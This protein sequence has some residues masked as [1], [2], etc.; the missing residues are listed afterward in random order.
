MHH[1][2]FQ[3]QSYAAFAGG[4]NP[5][6]SPWT[7]LQ[8]T[9]NPYTFNPAGINPMTLNPGLN[10]LALSAGIPF[11]QPNPFGMQ[12]GYGI[13]QYQQLQQAA[14]ILAQNPLA[15]AIL[16]NPVLAQQLALQAIQ[17]QY[18][19]PQTG[20]LQYGQ[21]WPAH[22][23]IGQSGS[24]VFGQGGMQSGFGQPA[25]GQQGYQLAPQ[26]WVGQPGVS[27]FGGRGIY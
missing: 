21:G 14:S 27:P 5:F 11:G 23:Q 19:Q 2:P 10:P 3:T 20:Q 8:T 24:P 15:C 9:V 6:G 17:Q 12:T 16:Q 22:P 13:P 7:T 25:F 26:S 4:A 1:D 18:G